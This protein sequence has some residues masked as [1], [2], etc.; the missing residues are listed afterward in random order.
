[1]PGSYWAFGQKLPDRA[2]NMTV[3][4]DIPYEDA[5]LKGDALLFHPDT[6]EPLNPERIF[7]DPDD[8]WHHLRW[9]QRDIDAEV[10]KRMQEPDKYHP[11]IGMILRYECENDAFRVRSEREA[12]ELLA[13]SASNTSVGIE[14]RR[15]SVYVSPDTPSLPGALLRLRSLASRRKAGLDAEDTDTADSDLLDESGHGDSG[16]RVRTGGAAEGDVIVRSGTYSWADLNLKQVIALPRGRFTVAADQ[17]WDAPWSSSAER[18]LVYADPDAPYDQF[19]P[20]VEGDE[21]SEGIK[22]GEHENGSADTGVD[23]GADCDD[24]KVEASRR[25]TESDAFAKTSAFL[26]R[27]TSFAYP[28]AEVESMDIGEERRVSTLIGC[29]WLEVAVTASFKGLKLVQNDSWR[30]PNGSL[31][32]PPKTAPDYYRSGGS[33]GEAEAR[34]VM[35]RAP[36]WLEAERATGLEDAGLAT[37]VGAGKADSNFGGYPLRGAEAVRDA[38]V[39]RAQEFDDQW[40]QHDEDCDAEER[41]EGADKEGEADELEIPAMS[42]ITLAGLVVLDSCDLIGGGEEVVSILGRGNLT[43]VN[44]RVCPKGDGGGAAV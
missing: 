40:E 2:P 18:S 28:E 43:M 31:A 6:M 9:D 30:F 7:G 22:G 20:A 26:K 41:E 24:A 32:L 42:C 19:L 23:P 10:R 14:R 36:D 27:Y 25:I 44:C 11:Y 4:Y 15:D 38:R 39:F 1:M 35:H 16:Q 17:R 21:S 8:P 12:T 34:R 37:A 3:G 5:Y 33:W 29:W 13:P